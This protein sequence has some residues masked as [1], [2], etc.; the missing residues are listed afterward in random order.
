MIIARNSVHE[1]HAGFTRLYDFYWGQI[2]MGAKSH[3]RAKYSNDKH[4]I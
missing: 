4:A 1:N 3:G 2:C